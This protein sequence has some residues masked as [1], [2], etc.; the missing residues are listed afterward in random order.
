LELGEEVLVSLRAGD[1]VP[2]TYG[3]ASQLLACEV[4]ARVGSMPYDGPAGVNRAAFA[5]SAYA[6][7]AE[8]RLRINTDLADPELTP[9]LGAIRRVD[10]DGVVNRASVCYFLV[11]GEERVETF[12]L[13]QMAQDVRRGRA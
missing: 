11:T 6:I 9:V 10:M 5:K 3:V 2:S 8:Q 1:V 4:K 13:S 12:V 7:I